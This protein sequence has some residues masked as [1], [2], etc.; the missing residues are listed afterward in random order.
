MEKTTKIVTVIILAVLILLVTFF[1]LRL[2]DIRSMNDNSNATEA[3]KVLLRDLATDYPLTV[4]EVIEYYVEIEKCF[5][6]DKTTD[7]ELKKLG[8]RARELYDADLLAANSEEYN[9]INLMSDVN[10][11]K[12]KKRIITSVAVASSINVD[13]FE[14]DGYKFARIGCS[15]YIREGNSSNIVKIIYLLRRDD[16]RRW[17]I[18][19][20][21]NAEDVHVE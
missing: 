19:G 11:F 20:W 16:K 1:A 9:L 18:Y 7:E 13:Y 8:M 14:E 21:K 17:K 4:K 2:G 3:E 10:A 6:N 12:E 15:Y 5:Y